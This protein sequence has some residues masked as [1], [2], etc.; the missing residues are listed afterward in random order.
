MVVGIGERLREAEGIAAAF[1]VSITYTALLASNKQLHSLHWPYLLITGSSALLVGLCNVTRLWCH[2]LLRLKP[3]DVKWVMARGGLGSTS[4]CLGVFAVLAGAHVGSCAALRS[5]NSIV[6]S[7]GTVAMGEHFGWM[8]LLSVT[9]FV[10]GAVLAA[11]PEQAVAS[12]GSN[13]LGSCLALAS[14]VCS[15]SA[16]IV[17]RKLKEVNPAFLTISNMFHTWI[18]CWAMC[19]VP[20]VPS[21]SLRSMEGAHLQGMLLL[22]GLPAIMHFDTFFGAIAS[23]KCSAAVSTTIITASNMLLGYGL[24]YVLYKHLLKLSTLVGATLI[25][26]AVVAMLLAGRIDVATGTKAS[27]QHLE[28]EENQEIDASNLLLKNSLRNDE[29]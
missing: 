11:D 6:A 5:V 2:G 14:G 15:A 9:L 16:Y 25:F 10:V 4:N 23:Q 20:R 17:G 21:G 24:D 27:S 12:V 28:L 7:L 26:L 18:F 29:V 19:F 1:V 13:L 22:L 8:H 3:S